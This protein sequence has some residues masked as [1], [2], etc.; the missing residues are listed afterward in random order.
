[1]GPIGWAMEAGPIGWAMEAGPLV[2]L[3]RLLHKMNVFL[4]CKL[5]VHIMVDGWIQIGYTEC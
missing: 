4:T 2:G 5:I 1:M 3:W